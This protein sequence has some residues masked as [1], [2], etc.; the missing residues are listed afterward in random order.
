[1]RGFGDPEFGRHR[2]PKTCNK[3]SKPSV[4]QAT[5][6]AIVHATFISLPVYAEAC[7]RPAR[8]YADG[9]AWRVMRA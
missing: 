5:I 2:F 3:S 9:S 4:W 1:M 8:V 6:V 7:I